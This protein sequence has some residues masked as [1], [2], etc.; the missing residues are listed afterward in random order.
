MLSLTIKPNKKYQNFYDELFKAG[1]GM[2]VGATKN[3]TAKKKSYRSKTGGYYTRKDVTVEQAIE[4]TEEGAGNQPRRSFITDVYNNPAYID[5]VNGIIQRGFSRAG[6]TGEI[7][8]V[9]RAVERSSDFLRRKMKARFRNNNWAPI[10]KGTRRKS[11]T[12]SPL[13]HTSQ[14]RRTLGTDKAVPGK[15]YGK[16]VGKLSVTSKG[17]KIRWPK[18]RRF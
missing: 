8:Y 10:A 11:K 2:V 1:Y 18:M 9:T 6:R 3:V 14:M 16:V 4:W 5:K 13:L 7:K 15:R 12:R 17:T